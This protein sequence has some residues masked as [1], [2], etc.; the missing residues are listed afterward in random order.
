LN[1]FSRESIVIREVL[2]D[3]G[4]ELALLGLTKV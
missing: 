2:V 3:I 1:G 4:K